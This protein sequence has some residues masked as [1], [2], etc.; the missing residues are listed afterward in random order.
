MRPLSLFKQVT[1]H[2][3][4]SCNRPKSSTASCL[5]YVPSF[6]RLPKLCTRWACNFTMHMVAKTVSKNSRGNVPKCLLATQPN[7]QSPD[8][9]V[10]ATVSQVSTEHIAYLSHTYCIN[11]AIILHAYCIHIAYILRTYC[12]HLHNIAALT[13][14][15]SPGVFRLKRT[16][17]V[18]RCHMGTVHSPSGHRLSQ[19]IIRK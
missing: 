16:V 11:I 8:F 15:A 2:P 1:R 18:R 14:N 10:L 19:V 7:V 9:L 6:Q 12:M 17:T 5:R 4:R 3:V 13:S